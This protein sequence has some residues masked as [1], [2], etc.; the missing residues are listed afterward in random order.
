MAAAAHKHN[1]DTTISGPKSCNICY[2]TYRPSN[3]VFLPCFHHICYDCF[4]KLIKAVCPYCRHD[5]STELYRSDILKENNSPD[6]IDQSHQH[7]DQIFRIENY[8]ENY[9]ENRIERRKNQR[10]RRYRNKRRALSRI[11]Q[12][13]TTANAFIAPESTNRSIYHQT[14]LYDFYVIFQTPCENQY[15]VADAAV[16]QEQQH[17]HHRTKTTSKTDRTVKQNRRLDKKPRPKPSILSFR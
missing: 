12:T 14:E 2:E 9:V 6:E 1:V 4:E 5:F 10:R 7:E 3:V 13:A 15:N 16:P 8:V 11:Q 17:N